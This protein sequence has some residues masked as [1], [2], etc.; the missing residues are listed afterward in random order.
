MLGIT[1]FCDSDHTRS[2]PKGRGGKCRVR[3][4][5]GAS[6]RSDVRGPAPSGRTRTTIVTGTYLVARLPRSD[7]LAKRSCHKMA[8][9]ITRKGRRH[10][11]SVMKLAH[12]LRYYERRHGTKLSPEAVDEEAA[13][14]GFVLDHSDET[15]RFDYKRDREQKRRTA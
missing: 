10:I 9:M 11:P 4:G 6:L 8:P 7:R 3:F 14:E 15:R 2:G 12:Y 13:K 1:V 5:R